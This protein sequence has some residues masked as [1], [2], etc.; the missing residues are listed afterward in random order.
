MDRADL[1]K[2][3]RDAAGSPTRMRALA[4]ARAEALIVSVSEA[5]DAYRALG[6]VPWDLDF[7]QSTQ[8]DNPCEARWKKAKFEQSSRRFVQWLTDL[9]KGF[10]ALRSQYRKAIL[11]GGP[12]S[13]L[14][15]TAR[16]ALVTSRVEEALYGGGQVESRCGRI[17]HHPRSGAEP[18]VENTVSAAE[19]CTRLGATFAIGDYWA[20]YCRWELKRQN[21]ADHPRLVEL[22][23]DPVFMSHVH[24][25]PGYRPIEIEKVESPP[26]RRSRPVK[27]RCLE[28]REPVKAEGGAGRLGVLKM[29]E[30]AHLAPIFGRDTDKNDRLAYPD[31]F[32]SKLTA[33]FPPPWSR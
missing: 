11:L 26:W 12:E 10:E 19:G 27:R 1:R 9:T 33:R 8:F 29:N 4:N 31:D 16:F 15:A 30:G 24:E 7:T 20:A 18:L 14:A 2:A 6:E 32:L 13:S 17:D 28:K 22:S 23:P 21:P 5:W 25:D 3:E